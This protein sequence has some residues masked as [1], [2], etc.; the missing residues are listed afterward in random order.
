MIHPTEMPNDL[1]IA[2]KAKL[3][4]LEE[5]AASMGIARDLLEPYGT[6]VAKAK[7][8]AIERLSERPSAKYVVVSAKVDEHGEVVGLS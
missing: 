8:D 1:Q 4:P 2:R 7:L 6:V 3:K 5:V